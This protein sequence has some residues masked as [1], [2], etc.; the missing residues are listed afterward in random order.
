MNFSDDRNDIR[1]TLEVK[2]VSLVEHDPREFDVK[3]MLFSDIYAPYEKVRRYV[4][5]KDYIVFHF[6]RVDQSPAPIE[7]LF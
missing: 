1:V 7:A 4:R 5:K 3:G 2:K 6:L